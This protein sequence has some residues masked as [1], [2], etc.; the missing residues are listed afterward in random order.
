MYMASIAGL[1]GMAGTSGPARRVT[2]PSRYSKASSP[3]MLATS[4]PMPPALLSSWTIR[5][6]PVFRTD[7]RIV[8]ESNGRRVRRSTT[9]T[10]TPSSARVCAASRQWWTI[11]P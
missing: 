10:E 3:M 2:G 5:A 1:K 8:S 4:P 9:S 11:S 7:S 6:L